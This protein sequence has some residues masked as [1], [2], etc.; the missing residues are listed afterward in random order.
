MIFFNVYFVSILN[1]WFK[2]I[3]C[4][5]VFI[6]NLIFLIYFSVVIYVNKFVIGLNI[7]VTEYIYSLS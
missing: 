1:L 7:L 3:F 4:L 5:D 6:I 2:F